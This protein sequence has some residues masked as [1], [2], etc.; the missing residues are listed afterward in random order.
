MKFPLR[1][2]IQIGHYVAQQKRKGDRYPL[3]LMLGPRWRAT[4]PASAAG[5]S[6]STSRTRRG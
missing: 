2:T 6:A 4:S 1:S 3:V 5:R